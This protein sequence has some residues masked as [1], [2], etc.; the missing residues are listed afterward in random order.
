MPDKKP[1]QYQTIAAQLWCLPQ[2]GSKVM[3]CDFAQSIADALEKCAEE[4]RKEAFLEA[5][6]Y[7]ECQGL[8]DTY[9]E[10]CLIEFAKEIRSMARAAESKEG[11][12]E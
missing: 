8:P 2:H 7:I 1:D 11:E 6:K 12:G 5:A 3:D 9:S 10:P 4:A